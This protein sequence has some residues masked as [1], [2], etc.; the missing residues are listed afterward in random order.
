MVA[1]AVICCQRRAARCFPLCS[2]SRLVRSAPLPLQ[3]NKT[4]Q[5]SGAVRAF[6]RLL[7]A[8][9]P[10][11]AR[12]SAGAARAAAGGAGGRRRRRAPAFGLTREGLLGRGADLLDLLDY[13]RRGGEAR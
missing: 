5:G 7:R 9:W 10:C 12:E 11:G 1:S 8:M 2:V 13:G 3:T 6:G 4:A